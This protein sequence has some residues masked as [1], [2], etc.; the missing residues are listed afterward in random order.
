VATTRETKPCPDCAEDILAKAQ[1]CRFCGYRFSPPVRSP[2]PFSFLRPAATTPDLPAL[3]E[4]W[5]VE[6]A[7]DEEIAF[8]ALGQERDQDGYLLVTNARVIFFAQAMGRGRFAR[9]SPIPRERFN[10]PIA[11]IRDVEAGSAHRWGKTW[12]RLTG[13]LETV[14]LSGFTSKHSAGEVANYLRTARAR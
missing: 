11:Q 5:G 14:T 7:E 13:P 4:G 2:S 8:F 1:V 6:L 3:L 10:V 12:L 9:R